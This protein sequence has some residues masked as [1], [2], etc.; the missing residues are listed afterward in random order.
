VSEIARRENAGFDVQEGSSRRRSR[1]E[2][3]VGVRQLEQNLLAVPQVAHDSGR[4]ESNI[5]PTK[6]MNAT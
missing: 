6:V 4:P 2:E 1:V 3:G 5:N